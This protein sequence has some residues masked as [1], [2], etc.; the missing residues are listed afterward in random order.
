MPIKIKKLIQKVKGKWS[1]V[2]PKT[3]TEDDLDNLIL[4]TE[5]GRRFVIKEKKKNGR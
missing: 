5:S 4:V 1:L 2:S 3:V